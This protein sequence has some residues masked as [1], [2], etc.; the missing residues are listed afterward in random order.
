MITT[1]L[2]RVEDRET[3]EVMDVVF[4]TGI[5][6]PGAGAEANSPHNAMQKAC[7]GMKAQANKIGAHAVVGVRLDTQP[8]GN[9]ALMLAY[10][11]AVTLEAV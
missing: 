3:A 5:A 1:V 6:D 9:S 7:E 2:E 8:L 4:G 11:T 10:G